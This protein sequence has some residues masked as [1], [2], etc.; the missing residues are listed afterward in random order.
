MTSPYQPAPYGPP[1]GEPPPSNL[2]WG[3]VT[4]VLCGGGLIGL[5]AGIVS[6]VNST[7]VSSRWA[8]GDQTGAQEASRKAKKWAVWGLLLSAALFA[9]IVAVVIAL[10]ASGALDGDTSSV[11]D[12]APFG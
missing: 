1:T 5:V 8:V 7:Q 4:I 12:P 11:G 3:I 9:L 6:I 2:V 10:A